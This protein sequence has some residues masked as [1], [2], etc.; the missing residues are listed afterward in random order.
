MSF[1]IM[2]AMCA[3]LTLIGI[4]VYYAL[5]RIRVQTNRHVSDHSFQKFLKI[6]VNTMAPVIRQSPYCSLLFT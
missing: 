3:M 1:T 6:A 2:I 5:D 4:V